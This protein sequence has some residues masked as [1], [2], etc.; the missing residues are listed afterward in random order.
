VKII[1]YTAI[2]G[3][4]DALLP[5]PPGATAVAFVTRKQ[6][7]PGWE[8]RIVIADWG[9][10]RTA[11]HYK[12]LP[13]RYLPDA[14]V[15]I[16]L[17]GNV[18][19]S[20]A[21]KD[22]VARWL[23]GDL[24]TLKHWERDCLYDE[25]AFCAKIGKDDKVTLGDQARRYQNAGM[26]RHWGLAATR[27]VMRRNTPAMAALNEAWWAELQ[28][29]SVRDQVSLPYVCWKAGLRW[30]VIPG[31]LVPGMHGDFGCIRHTKRGRT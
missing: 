16:W 9:P 6:N 26:P 17:D 25:A 4:C 23:H 24:A 5:P 14:N 31:K 12:A 21:P 30:D 22:A 13:N 7:A 8:Q 2:I 1:V 18:S 20:I 19:M 11:R 29:G 3:D 15:T 28:A 27:V 10:R